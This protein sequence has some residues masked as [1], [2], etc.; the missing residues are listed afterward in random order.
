MTDNHT[1]QPAD[2]ELTHVGWWC[3]R[4][5]NHGHLATQPC[6]SDNV[7]LHAPAE[8]ADEMRAVIQRIE[9]GDD[10]EP[11]GPDDTDLT[12]TDVDR[13]MAAGVPVQ[14][15]TAPPDTHAAGLVAVPPTTTDRDRIAAPARVYRVSEIRD[16]ELRRI[17]GYHA[18]LDGAFAY[19]EAEERKQPLIDSVRFELFPVPGGKRWLVHVYA[20][21]DDGCPETSDLLITEVD[22]IPDDGPMLP[23]GSEDTTTTRADALR[24]AADICDEAGA[25]YASKDLN[26]H[27]DVA[28]RLMER[29]QRKANEA[30]YVATPCDSMNPCEDGGE[31]CHIH[32]RLMA[33][34]EGDHELCGPD[35]GTTG[36]ELRRLAA[37]TQ[38]AEPET[39]LKRAHV[40][41]AEQAGRDQ[42]ALARVRRLHDALNTETGFTSPADPITRGAAA[43]KIAAALDGRTEPTESC[44]DSSHQAHPGFTCA[45]VDQTRPYWEGR[46]GNAPAVVSAVPPQPEAGGCCGKPPGAVC[47]HDLSAVP[48][49]PEETA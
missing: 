48:P 47:V 4:G 24:E 34:A 32:E 19:C 15:V 12:E 21:P 30:E 18:S 42:A 45:E 20:G 36:G 44:A 5:D 49:Q 9:D 43:W 26:D 6:R 46:W 16:N 14:I 35:C 41:L 40:A 13:M 8:W 33:H 1:P 39:A 29:F 31:P 17:H 7:P 2:E 23:A 22:V 11:A 27:A 37:E 3:W 10:G 25:V 38:P 28:Y